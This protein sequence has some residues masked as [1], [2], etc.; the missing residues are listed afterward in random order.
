M[1]YAVLQARIDP[2]SRKCRLD[3]AQVLAKERPGNCQKKKKLEM[4]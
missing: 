4:S 2:F 1:S 3:T